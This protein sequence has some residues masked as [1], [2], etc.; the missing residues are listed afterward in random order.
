MSIMILKVPGVLQAGQS[1]GK[2][3]TLPSF[4]EGEGL[5]FLPTDWATPSTELW[6]TGNGAATITGTPGTSGLAVDATNKLVFPR[7]ART[8]FDVN[9]Q[10]TTAVILKATAQQ[11]QFIG[12]GTTSAN[13]YT[14]TGLASGATNLRAISHDGSASAASDVAIPADMATVWTMVFGVFTLTTSQIAYFRSST[15]LTLGTQATKA[16]GGVG[17]NAIANQVGGVSGFGT[18][19][20]TVAVAAIWDDALTVPEMNEVCVEAVKLMASIGETL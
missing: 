3:E 13:G 10:V 12:S 20:A 19:A 4:D 18:S 16:S 15:G 17:S 6:G 9:S 14:I 1:L 2:A 11:Q 5:Y 8:A 7:T